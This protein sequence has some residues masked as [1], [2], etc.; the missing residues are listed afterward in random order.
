MTST[1]GL[2]SQASTPSASLPPRPSTT[3]WSGTFSVER[4]RIER[5][6]LQA[7][8]LKDQG[9]RFVGSGTLTVVASAS[10]DATGSMDGPLG[11]LRIVGTFADERLDARIEPVVASAS[12]FS[13][14]LHCLNAKSG[15]ALTCQV[16][17]STGDGN[18][19]RSGQAALKPGTGGEP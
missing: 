7:A 5:P 12:A 16:A 19:V 6:S 11:A 2:A 4:H 18:L 10:G 9:D 13:G 14:V 15:A 8:W 17:A 1:S 3:A